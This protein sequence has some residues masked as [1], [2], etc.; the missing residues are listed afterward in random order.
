MLMEPSYLASTIYNFSNLLQRN[1]YFHNSHGEKEQ[2]KMFHFM[3]NSFKSREKIPF[4]F[5]HLFTLNAW[6]IEYIFYT[7]G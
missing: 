4:L 7:Q 6:Y 2:Q 3:E 1:M 5:S